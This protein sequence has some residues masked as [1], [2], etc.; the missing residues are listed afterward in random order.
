MIAMRVSSPRQNGEVRLKFATYGFD[1][2]KGKLPLT[3][4]CRRHG[5]IDQ[6]EKDALRIADAKPME[7]LLRFGLAL[8]RQPAPRP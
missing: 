3:G 1:P 4:I 7:C 6:V 5:Q 8:R 2:R